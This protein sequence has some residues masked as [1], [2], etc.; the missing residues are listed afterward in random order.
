MRAGLDAAGW[1]CVLAVDSDPDMVSVHRLSHGSGMLADVTELTPEDIPGADAWVA[2]FPC[3]PFSTSGNRLGFGHRSGNVFEHLTRLMESRFP[4]LVIFEN[5]EGLLTNKSG[6][7]FAVVLAK[8]T[9]LGYAVSWLLVDLLAFGTPQTRPR[10]FL[11]AAQPGVLLSKD[12]EEANGVLPGMSENHTNAFAGFLETRGM[13][14]LERCHGRLDEL[15][16]LLRPAV[17]K[18]RVSQRA[19]FG[20]L[21]YA[22]DG[23]YESFDVHTPP[24]TGVAPSLGE[25][26]APGCSKM[27]DIRSGRYYARGGPTMLCLRS[28]PISHCIGTSLGG[29][30]LYAIPLSSVE[31]ASDRAAFLEFSNW[32]REQDGVLVMRLRPDRAVMLFGPHTEALHTAVSEW[33]AGDTRKY[34][35]VGNMVAPVCAKSVAELVNEQLSARFRPVSRAR[36]RLGVSGKRTPG[37]SPLDHVAKP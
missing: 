19:V 21:G 29:A 3:Q 32:Y 23:Y 8:L 30:P 24:N 4:P 7:T 16:R 34:K 18:A 10:L 13:R 35:I 1:K 37:R 25:L 5:V 17:G 26:V 36:T 6:H 12:L 33:D 28:E 11:V 2:G 14:W 27:G 20:S 15:E 9:S 31:N 22:S